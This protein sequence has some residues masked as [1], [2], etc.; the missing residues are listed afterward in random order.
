MSTNLHRTTTKLCKDCLDGVPHEK[1]T[2]T[3]VTCTATA[4]AARSEKRST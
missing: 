3:G 1:V 2:A 4:G